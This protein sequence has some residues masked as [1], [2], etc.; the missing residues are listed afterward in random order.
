MAEKLRVYFM[1]SGQIAVPIVQTLSRPGDKLELIGVGT[2][3]DRPSGRRCRLLPTPVGAAAES[4][5][6]RVD[7]IES[8]S[9]PEFEANLRGLSPDFLLVVS[10][11]Q[12]LRENILSIPRYGCVNVH[13]SVLP[14]Y[15]GAS[16][17]SSALANRDPYTGVTF[18]KMV[19]KLDAGD[20]YRILKYPLSGHERC[21]ELELQL[22]LLAAVN[23]H[24]TLEGIACG[25]LP[26]VAQDESQVTLTHKIKKQ[27]GRIIWSWP[28]EKIEAMTRA[29]YPWPGATMTLL[30]GDREERITVHSARVLPGDYAPGTI[31]R[32]DK[33]GFFIACGAG[34]LELLE[35]TPSGRKTMPAVAY[36]N[37]CRIADARVKLEE[38]EN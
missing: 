25:M 14:K 11:G 38:E 12:L 13:A 7:K 29:Y 20:I 8:A 9:S 32:A 17:I 37:G 28:A 21:D 36:L 34:V 18:M 16:P 2:Q 3:P 22:G 27:D 35:I 10:F 19:K 1:G 30:F 5:G 24:D 33:N 23:V 6:W 31:V 15:R 4:L 26:G